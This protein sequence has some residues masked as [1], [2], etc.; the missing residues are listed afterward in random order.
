MAHT[1][2]FALYLH[3]FGTICTILTNYGR[4]GGGE[5]GVSDFL[6]IRGL[7]S[8]YFGNKSSMRMGTRWGQ[9]GTIGDTENQ[10]KR[11]QMYIFNSEIS[12]NS[13]V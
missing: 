1:G 13:K 8:R 11:T 4:G 5:G 9:M 3:Y 7:V 2:G 6:G 10:G 12:N